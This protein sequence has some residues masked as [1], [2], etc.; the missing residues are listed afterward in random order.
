M[1]HKRTN[2]SVGYVREGRGKDGRQNGR[3]EAVSE[4]NRKVPKSNADAIQSKE[5]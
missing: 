2:R 1:Q 5:K 3:K 4:K